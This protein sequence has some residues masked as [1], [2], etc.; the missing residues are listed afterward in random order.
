MERKL[1]MAQNELAP[2]IANLASKALSQAA[3]HALKARDAAANIGSAAVAHAPEVGAAVASRASDVK[4]TAAE[5]LPQLGAAAASRAHSV[6][7]GE[8]PKLLRPTRGK[9]IAGLAFGA[10]MGAFFAYV[11]R[12]FDPH[13]RVNTQSGPT[14]VITER[15]E[16]GDPLRVMVAGNVYQSATYLDEKWNELP[17]EY[18]RAFDRMFDTPVNIERVLMLGGGG[19]AY[20]KHLLTTHPEV[21]MDVVESDLKVIQLALDY[22]YLDKLMETCGERLGVHE[23][24][25][26]TYLQTTQESFDVIVNDVFRGAIPDEALASPAGAQLAHAR[27]NPGGLYLVNVVAYPDEKN[28]Y[29]KLGELAATLEQAFEHVW[30][31]P[32]TDEEFSEDENYLVVASDTDCSFPSS[33]PY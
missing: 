28:A 5:R 1:T 29:A 8:L 24:D 17:F 33:I 7:G 31:I 20:P 10:A 11:M 3:V 19:F 21:S 16:A 9:V 14:Y 6:A 22:F 27:L 26:M 15:T 32:S 13:V 2:L 30:I 12:Y 23:Q 18:Y 4:S 25:A